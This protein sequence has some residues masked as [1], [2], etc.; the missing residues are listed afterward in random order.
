MVMGLAP[1]DLG[2]Y[3]FGWAFGGL[4]PEG[5]DQFLLLHILK[6]CQQF[7]AINCKS[8]GNDRQ[9]KQLHDVYYSKMIGH[10]HD[11]SDLTHK[12]QG[13]FYCCY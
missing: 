13:V 1:H 10:L 4:S 11:L 6:H 5:S 2:A 9:I 8:F 7:F 3:L 12:V